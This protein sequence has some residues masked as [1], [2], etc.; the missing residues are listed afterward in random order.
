[1][2]GTDNSNEGSY[3]VEFRR[4]LRASEVLPAAMEPL[5]RALNFSGRISVEDKKRSRSWQCSR[6]SGNRRW[7][8]RVVGWRSFCRRGAGS[9]CDAILIC[10]SCPDAPSMAAL[11][12]T[13]P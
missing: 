8:K 11:A 9:K 2:S 7:S 1:M 12:R 6:P 3:F 13:Y 5:L 4:K 10:M